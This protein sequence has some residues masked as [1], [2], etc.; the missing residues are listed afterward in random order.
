MKNNINKEQ[1]VNEL[2][3]SFSAVALEDIERVIDPKVNTNLAVFILGVCLIDALAGFRF[4][5]EEKDDKKDGQRFKDFVRIYL[6]QYDAN[7][8]WDVRNGLLH[9]YTVQGYSFVNK[10]PNLHN[11]PT[12]GGKFIND[13]DFYD[14]LKTAY[15]E[16]KKDVY[17]S[18]EI[19]GK[20]KKRYNALG[21]MKI[22][23]IKEP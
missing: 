4:G 14:D 20:A 6:T 18:E 1:L 8:L 22:T 9:S 2:D 19:F 17:N 11:K 5:K 16:F 3:S 23:V 10:K 21:L 7:D 13:E 15:G 12:K